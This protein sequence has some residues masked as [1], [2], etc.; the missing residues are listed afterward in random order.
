MW[1]PFSATKG[2]GLEARAPLAPL[3]PPLHLCCIGD[4]ADD[5]GGNDD[6]ETA[7]H[8]TRPLHGSEGALRDHRWARSLNKY[9]I[10]RQC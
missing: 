7:R 10:T 9:L 5:N 8:H 2:A 6:N 3:K 1:G 4:S